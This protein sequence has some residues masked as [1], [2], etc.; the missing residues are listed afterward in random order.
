MPEWRRPALGPELE[1]VARTMRGAIAGLRAAA[2]TLESFPDLDGEPR[3]L[4]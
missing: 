1:E 2:E 4:I 3:A